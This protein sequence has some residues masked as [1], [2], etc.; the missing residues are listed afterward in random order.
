MW[1]TFK[2]LIKFSEIWFK[3]WI[4]VEILKIGWNCEIWKNCEIWSKYCE[5]LTIFS[6]CEIWAKLWIF[7]LGKNWQNFVQCH[8]WFFLN[9]VLPI[10]DRGINF[11]PRCGSSYFCSSYIF[12]SYYYA[13]YIWY[14][15]FLFFLYLLILS[16]L[17][18]KLNDRIETQTL[19]FY[20]KI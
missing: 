10:F 1:S 9:L 4:F 16:L 18:E 5:I 15:L 13:S 3:L 7:E 14:V 17:I 12:S 11:R 2:I 19:G 8:I 6:N 20:H